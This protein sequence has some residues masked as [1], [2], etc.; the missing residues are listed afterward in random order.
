MNQLQLYKCNHALSEN[1]CPGITYYMLLI[2]PFN[3]VIKKNNFKCYSVDDV[4]YFYYLNF[5]YSRYRKSL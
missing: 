4:W 2:N 1:Y 5:F 3:P